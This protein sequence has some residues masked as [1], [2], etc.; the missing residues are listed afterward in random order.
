MKRA[1]LR[2][3]WT[4][5][6]TMLFVSFLTLFC[7]SHTLAWMSAEPQIGGLTPHPPEAHRDYP[8]QYTSKADQPLVRNPNKTAEDTAGEPQ[9]AK[10]TAPSEKTE[11]LDQAFKTDT[12]P[13]TPFTFPT[14]HPSIQSLLTYD[15]LTS[16][17]DT[18]VTHVPLND[19]YSYPYTDVAGVPTFRGNPTRTQPAYGYLEQRP[20]T[21]KIRWSFTTRTSSWGG[22]AGWTGQPA[23]INWPEETRQVMNLRSTNAPNTDLVEVIYGSL[24][25]RVYFFDLKNGEQ[26]RD[27]LNVGNP[28]KGSVS[29][30]TRGFPLLYVGEGIPETGE[31]GFGLYSLLD[32]SL[33]YHQ[34]GLDAQAF[35]SWGAFDSSALFNKKQDS[36]L[37]GGENGLLYHLQLRTTYEA[38]PP[39]LSI[40]PI[41][42]RYRYRVEGNEHQGIENAVAIYGN[43]AYFADNG[44]S[45][46]AI[47]LQTF[48][49]IW[50]LGPTDD[51]DATL[52]VDV[53]EETPYIY[54]ATEVDQQGTQGDASIRKINGLTGEVVWDTH[55]P[56]YSDPD[57][58]GGALA[59]NI[60]GKHEIGDVVIF[61]LARYGAFHKGLMV[62]LDKASG[63]EVW[64]WEMPYYAWSSPVDV[65]TKDGEAFLLQADSRGQL[66][67]LEGTTGVIIDQID[68]GATVEASPAVFND[69]LVLATRGQQI[70]G[71][72]M[73]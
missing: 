54:T 70:F 5:L 17:Q 4:K 47:D 61:T 57:V 68:L 24:D 50:V 55:Y 32:Q 51:T 27:P 59:T 6:P 19:M 49:P 11:P 58:N 33:L 14:P 10:R 22:G 41:V 46:Q 3:L 48:Q 39:S 9:K 60:V 72:Q 13:S 69:T 71:I 31:I 20:T 64:R 23:I 26:T 65:Y 62:A 28:I 7:W 43:L 8:D 45:V 66:S 15:I 53:E 38:E 2:N 25:G 29:V 40:D 35:R 1:K 36:M 21:L 56:C 30:D 42:S 44:G 73:Q 67:L 52:T 18:P 16:N 34:S 63:E 12:Y 37:V